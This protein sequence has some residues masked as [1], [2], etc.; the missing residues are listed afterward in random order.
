MS[1]INPDHL[2]HFRFIGRILGKAISDEHLLDAHFTRSFYKHIL[3]AA[4]THRDME[5]RLNLPPSL[6]PSFLRLIN[7]S[8]PPSLPPSLPQAIDPEYYKSLCQILEH[9]LEDL[10]LD[11]TFR[12]VLPSLP[13]SLPPSFS[14]GSV[15]LLT[16]LPPSL[17]SI[18]AKPPSSAW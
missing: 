16:S 7:H 5:V 13:P 6:P 10:G 11:L 2:A 15:V 8:H 3:G 14:I 4:V 1:S 12:Y 9:P 17:P 18:A